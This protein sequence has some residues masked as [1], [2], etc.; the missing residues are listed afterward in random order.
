M[1]QC[2]QWPGEKK[3]RGIRLA[4]MDM[5][6]PFGNATNAHAPEAAMLFHKFRVIRHLDA[7]LDQARK[8]E[9]ARI[10]SSSAS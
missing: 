5:W 4:V 10:S 1:A 6:K 7:A 9:Y 3:C 8:S 2:Y